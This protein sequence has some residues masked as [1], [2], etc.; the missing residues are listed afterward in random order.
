MVIYLDLVWAINFI[1]DFMLLLTI[2]VALKRYTKRYRLFLGALMGSISLISLFIAL[3]YLILTIFKLILGLLMCLIA[4]GYKNIKYTLAN[5]VYLYM[6]S[7]ILGGFLYFL[8]INYANFNYAFLLVIAQL[9]LYVFIKSSKALKEIKNYY[10]QVEIVFNKNYSLK[11]NGFLDTGNRL[12]EPLSKKPIIILN[13]KLIKGK[14][15]IRSPMYVPF[16]TLN[17]HG[18]LECFKV[19]KI[20]INN[21][22]LKNYL[23]GL[24]NSSF[25]INGIDCLLNYQIKEDIN[26]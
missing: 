12:R 16:N 24:S 4:F 10:Y 7:F 15:N 22:I 9:I 26:V 3:N 6:L 8:K 19:D 17:N 20:I 23:I 2:N 14:I 11:V 18:L 1:L 21:C 25:H 13:K 5:L